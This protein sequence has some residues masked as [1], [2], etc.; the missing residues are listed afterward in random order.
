[1][2]GPHTALGEVRRFGEAVTAH[3]DAAV[4]YRETGDRHREGRTLGNLAV[5]LR[6]KRQIRKAL[7]AEYAAAVIRRDSSA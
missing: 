1:V 4:I 6:K 5:A 3:Q 2:A 7:A